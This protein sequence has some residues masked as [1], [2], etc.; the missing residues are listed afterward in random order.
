MSFRAIT[1]N[2]ID[3]FE[4]VP[5]NFIL[6]IDLTDEL[7]VRTEDA[8]FHPKNKEAYELAM[9]LQRLSELGKAVQNGLA[10]DPNT[11]LYHKR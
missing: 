5:S 2:V 3:S 8:L 11:N 1:E 10:Y 4:E 9:V 7:K 6:F